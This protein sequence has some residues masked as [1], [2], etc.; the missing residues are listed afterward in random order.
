MKPGT[1]QPLS[2][3]PLGQTGVVQTVA[4]SD[5][6]RRFW[7]LGLIPGTA[8]TPLLVSPSGDPVA[9]AFRGTVIAL[10]RQDA[11]AVLV[12]AAT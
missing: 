8:V 10:R 3:L 1:L 5:M 4:A 2:A 6:T 11:A 7:D 12:T 9:Y